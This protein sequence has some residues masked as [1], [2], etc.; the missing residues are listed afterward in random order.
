MA[1]NLERIYYEAKSEITSRLD[2]TRQEMFFTG[3]FRIGDMVDIVDMDNYGN[4][5]SIMGSGIV[6]TFEKDAA[7]ILDTSVDTSNPTGKPWAMVNSI[8]NGQK[9]ID[10]LYSTVQSITECEL[11]EPI[12]SQLSPVSY[13]VND[14]GIFRVGDLG[15]I[16]HSAGSS[17]L[18]TVMDKIHT[19]GLNNSGEIVIDSPI[20]ISTFINPRFQIIVTICGEIMNLKDEVESLN[21]FIADDNFK[22]ISVGTEDGTLNGTQRVFVNTVKNQILAASDRVEHITYADFGLPT[23]RIT[24]IDYSAMSISSLIARKTISYSLIGSRYRKD[25]ITWSLI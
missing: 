1:L 6:I 11:Q 3:Y 19:G 24:S 5:I 20:D 2:S 12:L 8:A 10:R 22:A 17:D 16:I 25:S 21:N 4:I 7:L 18:F 23:Q 14:I 13:Q 15:R 9:A